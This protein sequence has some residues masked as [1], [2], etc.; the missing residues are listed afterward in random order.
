[1]PRDERDA[2][3]RWQKRR[4]RREKF[5][6]RVGW[7]ER[8][9]GAIRAIY[10][11][12]LESWQKAAIAAIAAVGIAVA[13][14]VWI[15]GKDYFKSWLYGFHDSVTAMRYARLT[16]LGSKVKVANAIYDPK[17]DRQYIAAAY[18]G[19]DNEFY[20]EA[21]Q[22]I[23]DTPVSVGNAIPILGNMFIASDFEKDSAE[24]ARHYFG[25]ADTRGDGGIQMYGVW[26]DHTSQGTLARVF[27][28]ELNASGKYQVRDSLL[29]GVP[30]L[31]PVFSL[32]V[33]NDSMKRWL[34]AKKRE[35]LETE[36][37][38]EA[39]QSEFNNGLWNGVEAAK[40]FP[41]TYARLWFEENGIDATT[42]PIKMIPIPPGDV[43]RED[44][45]QSSCVIEVGQDVWFVA[46]KGPI[47]KY[48]AL[49]DA[50][51]LAYMPDP[52]N[53][54]EPL[55][56]IAGT[57]YLWFAVDIGE[58]EHDAFLAM[59]KTDG[60]FVR[61]PV[62][63]VRDPSEVVD[64]PREEEHTT[65]AKDDGM[66][67]EA[68]LKDGTLLYFKFANGQIETE[69]GDLRFL[70]SVVVVDADT[71]IDIKKEFAAPKNC[72]DESETP[73]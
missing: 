37:W 58:G 53:H 55:G 43:S 71:K 70:Q 68:P 16:H 49:S 67:A 26:L 29:N 57:D 39:E 28:T 51:V 1:M 2:E 56:I 69:D 31:R 36:D 10:K 61:V 17:T 50:V 52:R 5:A 45:K 60:R 19:T 42:G 21:F 6:D 35:V 22:I 20:A 32:S 63:I 66:P 64:L 12:V 4:L 47:L 7:R 13:G 54:R 59:R 30:V 11:G 34:L 33:S 72:I 8:L 38:K 48:D 3:S 18:I 14:S 41:G 73:D 9:A 46:F 15:S 23:G 27:L 62:Q 65:D 24:R 40:W 44:R 25:F